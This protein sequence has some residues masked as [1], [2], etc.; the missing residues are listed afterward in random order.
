MKQPAQDKAWRPSSDKMVK[1]RINQ[2]RPIA[3]VGQPGDVVEV[4]ERVAMNFI[5]Q[6][7]A[8]LELENKEKVA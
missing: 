8:I 6:G 7:L 4:S 1:I 2:D 5:G 3:G